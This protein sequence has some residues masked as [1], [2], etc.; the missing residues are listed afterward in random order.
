MTGL[1]DF[2]AAHRAGICGGQRC[3]LAAGV[4]VLVAGLEGE[5]RVGREDVLR[6]CRPHVGHLQQEDTVRCFVTSRL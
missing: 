4:S 3:G 6:L 5:G 1:S 2:P